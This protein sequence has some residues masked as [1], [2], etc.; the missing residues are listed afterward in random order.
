MR[1]G[2]GPESY[3]YLSRRLYGEKLFGSD[4]DQLEHRLFADIN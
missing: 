3:G 1:C 2:I 4:G